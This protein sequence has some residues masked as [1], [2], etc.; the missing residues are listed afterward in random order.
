MGAGGEGRGGLVNKNGEAADGIGS[1]TSLTDRVSVVGRGRSVIISKK[2]RNFYAPFMFFFQSIFLH[3]I[4]LHILFSRELLSAI[5]L[6]TTL[7]LKKKI[8][9]VLKLSSYS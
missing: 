6:Q 5:Y 4:R 3:N 1:E 2:C 8:S 9:K 7:S